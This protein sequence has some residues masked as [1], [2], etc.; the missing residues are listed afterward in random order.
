MT[1][2][3]KSVTLKT[4]IFIAK[5]LKIKVKDMKLLFD[6]GLQSMRMKYYPPCLEPEKVIG[7]RPH[8]DP[9]EITFVIQINEVEGLQIKKDGIWIPIKPLPNAFMHSQ[10]WAHHR[11]V[12]FGPAPSLITHE[13]PPK[14]IR[15]SL[16]D[17]FKKFFSRELKTKSNIEQYCI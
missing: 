8:S 1:R 11:D 15:V 7:L 2:E 13:T 14:F 17:Y 9:L 4:L 3:I 10:S 12:D 5:D 16:V 6:E